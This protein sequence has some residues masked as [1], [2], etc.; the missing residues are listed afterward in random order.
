[1]REGALDKKAREDNRI[2][3]NW[4]LW[5]QERRQRLEEQREEILHTSA[6]GYDRPVT[7]REK[8]VGDPTAN[9]AVKLMKLEKDEKWLRLIEDIEKGLSLNDKTFLKLRRRYRHRRGQH[10][11]TAKMQVEYP[12]AMA[13]ATG[14]KESEFWVEHRTTF[15]AWWRRIID[16]TVREAIRRSLL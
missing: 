3:A 4:L 10:G 8:S 13:K 6:G 9:R 16:H 5:C 1:M 7:A 2:A 15:T 14:K 12:K 11:W